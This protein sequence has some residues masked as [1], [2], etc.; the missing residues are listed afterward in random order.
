MNDN[1]GGPLD[2][3]LF[4]RLVLANQYEM[5][6]R[7]DPDRAEEHVDAATRIRDWWPLQDLRDVDWMSGARQDP[8]LLEDQRFVH[9]VLTLYSVLQRAHS[10]G[11]TSSAGY[12]APKFRGFC[13]NEEG[14]Y[15]D[16]YRWLLKTERYVLVER[17]DPDDPNSHQA[18]IETYARM[19]DKWKSLGRPDELDQGQYDA[20]MF[21]WIHPSY[22]RP[23]GVVAH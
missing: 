11:C 9:D 15:L 13:G 19:L 2:T 10:S 5:L 8:L 21:E 12:G 18:M 1:F 16:Y 14:K 17:A 20:I 22:R 3:E 6:A 7:L 4:Q 23:K